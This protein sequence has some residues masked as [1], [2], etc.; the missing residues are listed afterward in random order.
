M[1]TELQAYLSGDRNALV[2]TFLDEPWSVRSLDEA[3][4]RADRLLSSDARMAKHFSSA[5]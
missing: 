2:A 5:G 3:E 4:A 1:E